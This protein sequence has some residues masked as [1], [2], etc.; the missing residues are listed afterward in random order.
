MAL[1]AQKTKGTLA[2]PVGAGTEIIFQ[3][4]TLRAAQRGEGE[5]KKEETGT[6]FVVGHLYHY[7][8]FCSPLSFQ[9]NLSIRVG[10]FHLAT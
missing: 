1:Q 4:S 10:C 6:E 2:D 8:P 3:S 5:M 9:L 7:F